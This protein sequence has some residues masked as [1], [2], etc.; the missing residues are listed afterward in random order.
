MIGFFQDFFK[1]DFCRPPVGRQLEMCSDIFL[2]SCSSHPIAL[3]CCG[4]LSPASLKVFWVL[5]VPVNIAA[6]WPLCLGPEVQISF[7]PH[8]KIPYPKQISGLTN[9]SLAVV[10]ICKLW[11]PSARLGFF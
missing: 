3:F 5:H 2:A 4:N 9:I 8:R 7:M 1:E 10:K 6:I 11:A